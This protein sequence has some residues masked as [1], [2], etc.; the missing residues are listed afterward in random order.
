MKL[1]CNSI[2]T[3][4]K[5]RDEKRKTIKKKKTDRK[6]FDFEFGGNLTKEKKRNERE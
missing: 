4:L 3:K 5:K 1:K 6:R 2:D